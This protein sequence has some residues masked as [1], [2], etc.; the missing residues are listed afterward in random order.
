M[1]VGGGEVGREREIEREKEWG[2]RVSERVFGG[3]SNSPITYFACGT[4]VGGGGGRRWKGC[5]GR[6]WGMGAFLEREGSGGVETE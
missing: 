5:G 1:C 3:G 4:C 2:E 6:V